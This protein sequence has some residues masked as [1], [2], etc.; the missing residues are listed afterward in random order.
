MWISDTSI[1]QPI[2]ITMIMIALIVVGLLAYF[3]LPVDL[4][5]DVSIPV[6]SVTTIYPGAS[7]DEIETRVSKVL[8]ESLGSLNGV[9]TIQSTSAEGISQLVIRFQ[10][11]HSASEG[12][13]DVQEKIAAIRNRLPQDIQ[14]PVIQQFDF[15]ALP[16]MSFAIAPKEGQFAPGEL[17]RRA[18][19]DIKPLFARIEGVA[20]VG[21]TGGREREI[22]VSLNLASL[23]ARQISPQQVVGAI[24]SQ[25]IS[26]PA[27]HITQNGQD[28]LIRTPGEFTSLDDLRN[29]VVSVRGAPVY[30]R[31]IA[32]VED[33][34][35]DVKQLSRLNGQDSVVLS[36][37]KQSGTNTVQVA[38]AVK[39][40]ITKLEKDNP[41]LTLVVARDDSVFVKDSTN[42]AVFD[43][44]LGGLGAMLV[45]LLFFRDIRN[46]L[47]TV[48]GL[49]FI[50]I[51]TFGVM[52][53]T[54]L[55]INMLTLLALS[56]SVGLVIDDAIVVRENI[57]RHMEK[58][59]HPK[60]ASSRGT[61]EV[62]LSVM[63]M[64]FTIVSVFLPV[65]FT[66]GITG[67][68]FRSFGLTVAFA[69]L[70]SLFEAFTFAPMLSAY[71]FKQH[72]SGTEEEQHGSIYGRVDTLYRRFLGWT[73]RHKVITALIAVV[74]FASSLATLPF[75]KFAFLA[76]IGQNSLDMGIKLA[77]GTTLSKTDAQVRKV[78]A[79]LAQRPE[80]ED[81]LT[82]VGS[83]GSP[84][85]ATFFVKL[86]K[87]IV[88]ENLKDDL[89]TSLAAV[90]G[91]A[92]GGGGMEG[93]S[94]TSV[95]GRAIQIKLLSTGDFAALDQ[96]SQ[97]VMAAIRDV[98]G[99]VGLTRSYE[100]GKPEMQI[101]VDRQRA[102]DFGLSTAQ[103][104]STV[105]TLINGQKASRYRLD[106]NEADIVVRLRPED[107]QNTTGLL[108]LYVTSPTGTSIPLGSVARLVPAS[109]PTQI[110]RED[111][112][113][114][115]IV[116]A[117]SAGR[118]DNE[119]VQDIRKRLEGVNL[120]DGVTLSFGGQTEQM[121][122]SFS[123]L[124][125][126]MLLAVIF[127]YMVLASQ[128]GSFTQPLVIMLALPLSF[129]GAFLGLFL[130]SKPMDMM[131]LIGIIMLMGL[132]TKNS[133]MLV[134]FTN[135][136]RERGLPRDEALMEAG[137][138]RLR[139]II[140][141]TLALIVGMFPVALGLG[142][143]GGFRATMAIAVIGGLITSTL[144][145]LLLVPAAYGLMDDV[146]NFW[147][148]PHFAFL[149]RR[150][151]VPV[152]AEQEAR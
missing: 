49:P 47:V 134:D 51:G 9:D 132:V 69:V 108:S 39:E 107:R 23:Q 104:G 58:G 67:R 138:L 56:L 150:K 44:I 32:T 66:T 141:T 46:T 70:I 62:G 61:A 35:K 131:A 19:D 54:G 60:E 127:V 17:R 114:E 34:F 91:L 109:G 84:E 1:K 43:L 26:V 113:R 121:Q 100:P 152:Q 42:D 57:F 122:K 130:T 65:A 120:P 118:T 40:E 24:Q 45:V 89:R 76:D 90:P 82:T 55:T 77:A 81:V 85:S 16:I 123:S 78:E 63:A 86:H 140:M 10:L 5:P 116:G 79:I 18:E 12:V 30:L 59:E 36:I 124:L 92:F 96:A 95:T 29:I 48:A 135:Q 111:Q 143:G 50:M 38:D 146:V 93:G 33:G 80:V 20:S 68:F 27:G 4:M 25:N 3:S 148:R 88:A 41:D 151:Q 137:L 75:L 72:E 139:P 145:T 73:L 8:E 28:L 87:G 64:T 106:G 147:R 128:F 13:R 83:R 149:R 37:Q 112:Q 102:A 11:E 110:F 105:R 99:L 52:Q 97:Q 115:I 31:D 103:I 129:V 117:N 136:A 21:V 125:T 133:I 98:P 7:P 144:L 126:A 53:L 101:V 94:A 74:F 22:H 2:F 142:A 14:D 6:V 15:G 119:V 71:F